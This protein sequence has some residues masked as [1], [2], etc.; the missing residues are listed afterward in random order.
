[1]CD[2]LYSY[3]FAF[4]RAIREPET[5]AVNVNKRTRV[6]VHACS[7]PVIG[8]YLYLRRLCAVNV[9]EN[10]KIKKLEH[11]TTSCIN[12]HLVYRLRYPHMHENFI[13]KKGDYFSGKL[14]SCCCFLSV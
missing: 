6:E 11:A 5:V 8:R 13:L 9:V 14:C 10:I 7:E 12:A 3:S 4:R 1:M 2:V